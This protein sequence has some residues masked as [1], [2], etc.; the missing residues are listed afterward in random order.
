MPDDRLP[1]RWVPGEKMQAMDGWAQSVS[2]DPRT[3]KGELA[4]AWAL[5]FSFNSEDGRSWESKATIAKRVGL[6]ETY[7]G[8]SLAG[9]DENGH[10]YRTEEKIRGRM[11]RVIRPTLSRTSRRQEPRKRPGGVQRAAP[12][13]LFRGTELQS[14][15]R[16]APT[17]PQYP[18]P[19]EPQYPGGTEPQYPCIL[20]RSEK[21]QKGS[22]AGVVTGC[23]DDWTDWF[24]EDDTIHIP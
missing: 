14:V 19:T 13:G 5:M 21:N 11:M 18:Y 7:V 2:K 16:A 12:N 10:I 22:V 17:E 4:V 9:L 20:D 24:D 8:G 3:T 6:S 23:D 15:A 1:C